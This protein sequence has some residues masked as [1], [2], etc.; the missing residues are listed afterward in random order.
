[1][2]SN[3]TALMPD[4]NSH[5][6]PF[7]TS[8]LDL[9]EQQEV[10]RA[11][12]REKL[13]GLV[14]VAPVTEGT[15]K[16][17]AWLGPI[18]RE[19]VLRHHP[20]HKLERKLQSLWSMLSVFNKA[21]VDLLVQLDRFHAFSL[22]EEMHLPIGRLQ[23][24]GIELAVNKELVAFSAA[25]GALVDFSRRLRDSIAV[26]EVSEQLAAIFD[27]E[28]HRFVTALRNV[29]CHQEFPDISWQINFGS[30]RETDFVMPA[31]G[32]RDHGALHQKAR[33][34]LDRSSKGI[35]VRALANSY[36]ARVQKFYGWY[37][38][39]LEANAPN[40]LG[41]YRKILRA[42]MANASRAT[43]RVIFQQLLARNVDPY[44]HLHKYLLPHQLEAAL[45]LQTHSKEQV[46]FII[47]IVDDHGACDDELRSQAYQLFQ[48][49]MTRPD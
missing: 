21:H 33:T 35:R 1:M 25:A 36:A 18:E 31:E 45:K 27:E 9:V 41:D 2:S 7:P 29:I 23:L 16:E 32:L 47:A 28:E 6:S 48:V 15:L 5:Q 49:P 13:A 43:Y 37:R 40:E 11:R 46:E 34:F 39:A 24:E 20:G 19:A 22:T 3:L 44:D 14:A 8:F 12:R 30:T 17:I 42:S 10:Q 26:P 4:T 38:T